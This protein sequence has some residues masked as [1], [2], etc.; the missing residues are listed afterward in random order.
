MSL[1]QHLQANTEALN[2]VA[3]MLATFSLNQ[4]NNTVAAALAT[5][6]KAAPK[7]TPKAVGARTEAE[8]AAA[9]E[10]EAQAHA[11]VN[12]P[13][14][15]AA[16][17]N[18]SEINQASADAAEA[19]AAGKVYTPA[20]VKEIAV[21]LHTTRGANVLVE[22]LARYGAQKVSSLLPEQSGKFAEE[23]KGLIGD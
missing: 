7:V 21:K 22:L 23:A 11:K 15:G 4:G 17:G 10:Y 9:A 18:G 19:A 2:A 13:E 3:A 8:V 1:E 20:E 14:E 12:E 5:P 16:K 6:A